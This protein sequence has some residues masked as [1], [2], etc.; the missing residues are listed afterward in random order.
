M[1]DSDAGPFLRIGSTF[2]IDES[3]WHGRSSASPEAVY[4]M[5]LGTR[6][7]AAARMAHG[8][9]VGAI[10]SAVRDDLRRDSLS[11]GPLQSMP[12]AVREELDPDGRHG[13]SDV[14]VIPKS[15]VTRVKVGPINNV[16][17]IETPDLRFKLSTGIFGMGKVRRFFQSHGYPGA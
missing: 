8:S 9:A 16:V 10:V 2:M 4:L 6:R 15:V 3:D 11:T 14:V 12:Q 1:S 17:V 7:S 13:E 5:K